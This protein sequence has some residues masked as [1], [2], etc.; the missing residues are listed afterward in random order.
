R[1]AI[2]FVGGVAAMFVTDPM[3]T[4]IVLVCVPLAIGPILFFGRQVRRHAR[5]SQ[6]RLAEVGAYVGEA[7]RG[8]KTVQANNHQE[9]DRRKFN[10]RV[11]EAFRAVLRVIRYRSFLITIV[12]A[13][14]LGAVGFMLRVA[15]AGVIETG[16]GAG[17]LVQFVFYA[18]LVASS[19][20]QLSEILG[21]LQRAAG[22]TERLAELFQA[23]N[24]IQPPK[25]PAQL[26]R[27]YGELRLDS[28]R[29]TYATRPQTPALHSITFHITAG[30]TFALV[31]PS[32]AGK[33]TLFDLLLRFYDPDAGGIYLDGQDIR[34]L[35][36]TEL[37]RYVGI[38]PQEPVLFSTSLLENIR[39]GRPDASEAEAYRAMQQACVTDFLHE[40]PEGMHTYLG[41]SGVRLSGGQ[42]QRVAIARAIL[43]D[44]RLLLLDEATSALDAHSENR[45][46]QA[47]NA[48]MQNRTTLV[49]AHRLATVLH[50]DRILVID[51]G[52]IIDQGTHR[53]LMQTSDLYRR[54]ADLQFQAGERAMRAP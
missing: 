37:R 53:E 47:L 44:P 12:I 30:S 33:S 50:A 3:L 5:N 49:I 35:H 39:Y 8:I 6:D 10:E 13:L 24:T 29:F 54:L 4:G 38:V 1:N 21:D 42:K 41:E 51:S 25:N 22:A 43:K 40:L 7:L 14:S 20:G 28:V 48:L 46:Q 32:G 17:K 45:V 26:T 27:A 11:E 36:P 52:R 9:L 15:G 31:G 19:V 18:F 34:N 23:R 2:M 16:E